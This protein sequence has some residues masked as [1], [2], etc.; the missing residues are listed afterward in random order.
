ML[1]LPVDENMEQIRVVDNV[2]AATW[3]KYLNIG[4]YCWIIAIPDFICLLTLFQ[5]MG[6]DLAIASYAM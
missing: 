5:N 2:Q 3:P 4:Y 6:L 1:F